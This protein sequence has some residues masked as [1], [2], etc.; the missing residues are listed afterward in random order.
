MLYVLYVLYA[1]YALPVFNLHK[2][3]P[4]IVQRA[5]NDLKHFSCFCLPRQ[6][7]ALRIP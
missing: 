1:L 4:Q 3:P 5:E 7:S 6:Y 2:A